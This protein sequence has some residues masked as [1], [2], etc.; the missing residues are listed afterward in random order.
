MRT[1][2]ST[3][4]AIVATI[5][6]SAFLSAPAAFAAEMGSGADAVRKAPVVSAGDAAVNGAEPAP[7]T[8]CGKAAGKKVVWT[9]K[10]ITGFYNLEKKGHPK[11]VKISFKGKKLIVKSRLQ[12]YGKK[13]PTKHNVF[14]MTKKTFVGY[15]HDDGWGYG[16]PRHNNP[17]W[18]LSKKAFSKKAAS[19]HYWLYI[20]VKDGRVAQ[21]ELLEDESL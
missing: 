9:P 13:T 19:G 18:R 12:T 10:E 6:V 11:K 21:A 5:L 16:D 8:T 20:I 3:L 7:I 2:V 14:K 15:Y 4:V 1:S 17:R